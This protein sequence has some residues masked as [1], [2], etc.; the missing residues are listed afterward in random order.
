MV[1]EAT[2][3]N[4]APAVS[5]LGHSLRSGERKKDSSQMQFQVPELNDGTSDAPHSVKA[6]TWNGVVRKLGLTN[7]AL[8]MVENGRLPS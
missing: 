4:K 6:N 3:L 1:V 7:P 2:E 8:R 5:S